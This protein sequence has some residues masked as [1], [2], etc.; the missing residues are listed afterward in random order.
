MP[1]RSSLLALLLACT[2]PLAA[3][4]T[5][6]ELAAAIRAGDTARALALPDAGAS[7][8]Q[9]DGKGSAPLLLAASRGQQSVARA[10]LARGADANPRFAPTTT[11]RR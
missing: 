9:T 4:Q 7:P 3:A 8:S 6:A 2:A 11:Q 5:Y 10:L 1:L